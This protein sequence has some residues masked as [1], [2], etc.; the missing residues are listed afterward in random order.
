MAFKNFLVCGLLSI[1]VLS[2]LAA[3]TASAATPLTFW[4]SRTGESCVIENNPSEEGVRLDNCTSG[5]AEGTISLPSSD[6]WQIDFVIGTDS[7]PDRDK[8]ETTEVRING[9]L[10]D[11]LVNDPALTPMP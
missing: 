10:I 8:T 4:S 11:T 5:F 9:S 7:D 6:T 1:A 3:S 2:L